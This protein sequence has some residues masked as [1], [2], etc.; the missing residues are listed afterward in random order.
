MTSHPDPLA[1]RLADEPTWR[2]VALGAGT[3]LVTLL[4][5]V[6]AVTA[7]AITAPSSPLSGPLH[8]AAVGL[9]VGL[10]F[11][12]TIRRFGLGVPADWFL[13]GRPGRR[14]LGWLA[15]GLAFPAAVLGLQ[16][17]LVGA[18]LVTSPPALVTSI[19]YGLASLAAGLLAGV[20]EELPLRGAMLRV[21][22]ARW[23]STRAVLVTAVVFAVLH[24]GHADSAAGLGLVLASMFA[25]GLLLGAVVIRTRNVWHAVAVHAGWNAVFGGQVVAAAPSSVSLTPAVLQFRFEESAVLL[26]GGTATLGAAPLTTALLVAAAAVVIRT[27]DR[28]LGATGSSR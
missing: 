13:A 15:V 17:W 10:A 27:P 7:A 18:T 19:G 1:D 4:A 8:Q 14:A 28:W 9:P 20:L 5:V 6:L 2:I 16:L 12:E 24:Q 22:E 26:T 23:S 25:A 11:Y 3:V 21:I